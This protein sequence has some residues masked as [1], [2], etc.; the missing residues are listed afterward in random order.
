MTNC[1]NLFAASALALLAAAGCTPTDSDQPVAIA[2]SGNTVVISTSTV[3][4]GG[5]GCGGLTTPG[6]GP[7]Y[8][9]NDRGATFTQLATDNIDAPVAA[10]AVHQQTFYAL[11][12]HYSGY[13]IEASQD[14]RTW[15]QVAAGSDEGFSLITAGDSLAMVHDNGL[16]LSRDGK[17]WID[18][19]LPA[20]MYNPIFTVAGKQTV[21]ADHGGAMYVT[22]DMDQWEPLT[23]PGVTSMHRLTN[24]NGQAVAFVHATRGSELEQPF[25][26]QLN[27]A[28][29][30]Q[31]TFIA[32]DETIVNLIDAPAGTLFNDGSA[33]SNRAQLATRADRTDA[34]I[35][36]AVDGN[37]V[38]VLRD[39]S[40]AV[41]ADGGQSFGPATELPL[42]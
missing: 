9:S 1:S 21:V 25:L 24:I 11:H 34:F 22:N 33:A 8:V 39:R 41:S 30:A 36:A 32:I 16:L 14:G 7:L 18:H 5:F 37:D 29:P 28:T 40:I 17:T 2:K 6:D 23:V 10:L 4:T 35:A 31:S 26:V 38:V 13:A 15:T 20:Q 27:L 19:A 3:T 12:S 42:R